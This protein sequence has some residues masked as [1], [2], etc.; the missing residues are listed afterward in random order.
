[1]KTRT[2]KMFLIIMLVSFLSMT[3]IAS[4]VN[5]NATLP[6]PAN[7]ATGV[8]CKTVYPVHVLVNSTNG[9]KFSV[10]FW[11][12]DTGSYHKS[13]TLNSCVNAT[14]YWNLTVNT[15]SHKYYWGVNYSN[16][17]YKNYNN[18]T[19]SF[20]TEAQPLTVTSPSPANGASGVAVS[21]KRPISVNVHTADGSKMTVFLWSTDTGAYHKDTTRIGVGNTTINWNLTTS[22]YDHT[23]TWGINYSNATSKNYHNVTYTFTTTTANG[24]TTNYLTHDVLSIIIAVAILMAIVGIAF[25]VGATKEGLITIMMVSIIGI[26][27]ISIIA[28]L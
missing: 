21:S 28:G 4:G 13:T 9:T 3:L 5:Y 18:R 14:Y 6:S 7:L 11:S 15:Y 2:S 20:T 25:T 1:M 10:F 17:T 8:Y 12:N 22:S 16:A 26:I 23:Y 19:Y 24:A 27:V